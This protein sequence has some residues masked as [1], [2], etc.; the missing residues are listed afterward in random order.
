MRKIQSDNEIMDV[1]LEKF[2]EEAVEA[3][4]NALS[5]FDPPSADTS[6]DVTINTIINI[7]NA[8]LAEIGWTRRIEDIYKIMDDEYVW[9]TIPV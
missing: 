9:I 6:A 1:L 4:G 3:F 7:L 8:K 5:P 2:G